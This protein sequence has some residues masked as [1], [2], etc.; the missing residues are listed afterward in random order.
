[1]ELSLCVSLFLFLSLPVIL[2]SSFLH[3]PERLMSFAFVM[4]SAEQP[5][6]QSFFPL[7]W[8]CHV[9]KRLAAPLQGGVDYTAALLGNRLFLRQAWLLSGPCDGLCHDSHLPGV[10]RASRGL[11]PSGRA[12]WETAVR[13][14]MALEHPLV[15]LIT[16]L[17]PAGEQ[18][19]CQLH[20]FSRA[21]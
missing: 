7:A 4:V 14:P 8:E 15:Q 11:P 13:P 12:G 17:S 18:D 9:N 21:R 3:P 1:M 5:G 19:A 16:Q 2:L 6:A 20:G 10:C